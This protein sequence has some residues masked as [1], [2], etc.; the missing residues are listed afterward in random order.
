M[1]ALQRDA[2][3]RQ[4]VDGFWMVG[5]V[6]LRWVSLNRY[7]KKDAVELAKRLARATPKTKYF[8]CFVRPDVSV[9]CASAAPVKVLERSQW[10]EIEWSASGT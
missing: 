5:A 9:F 4:Y 10:E 1:T 2:A 6:S 8:V 7:A 3:E